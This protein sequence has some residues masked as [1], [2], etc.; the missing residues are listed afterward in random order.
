MMKKTRYNLLKAR[1][2]PIISS[3]Q[4]PNVGSSYHVGSLQ[5][6]LGKN[7]ISTEGR[8]DGANNVYVVDSASL[9]RIPVGPITVAAMINA[10][11]IAEISLNEA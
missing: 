3:V 7:L 4:I 8:I 9:P 11:R 1:L 5:D 10:V 2:I 6:H